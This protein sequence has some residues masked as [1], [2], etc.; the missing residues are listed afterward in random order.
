[1]NTKEEREADF[2]WL[3]ARASRW[4][5]SDRHTRAHIAADA[6]ELG[7]KLNGRGFA[8]SL[9]DVARIFRVSLAEVKAAQVE[10]SA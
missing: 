7:F 3:T 8:V 2:E 1:M 4:L 5:E 10:R 9:H 6:Y